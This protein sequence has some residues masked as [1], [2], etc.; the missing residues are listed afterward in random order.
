MLEQLYHSLLPS[1]EQ[2]SSLAYWAAFVAAM[3][4]TALVVGL[5][6]AGMGASLSAGC[7]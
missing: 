3:A 5:L 4:E 6:G 2:F 1:L 7:P